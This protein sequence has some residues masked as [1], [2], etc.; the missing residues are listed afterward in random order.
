M[1]K[2]QLQLGFHG[3]KRKLAFPLEARSLPPVLLGDVWLPLFD[4]RS[5]CAAELSTKSST[6]GDP[7]IYQTIL[8]V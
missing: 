1:G 2:A 8:H 4:A 6:V 7:V 3:C 5:T